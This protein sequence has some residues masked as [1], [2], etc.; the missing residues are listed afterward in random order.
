MTQSLVGHKTVPNHWYARVPLILMCVCSF[1]LGDRPPAPRKTFRMHWELRCEH[2][3]YRSFYLFSFGVGLLVSAGLLGGWGSCVRKLSVAAMC[4][5]AMHHG[6]VLEGSDRR[7]THGWWL[8]S[9]HLH[10]S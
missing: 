8:K 1:Q 6:I 5:H 7:G 10:A 4:C 9:P 3:W 2:L